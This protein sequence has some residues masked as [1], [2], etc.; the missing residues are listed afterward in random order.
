MNEDRFQLPPELL[1]RITAGHTLPDPLP[2]SPFPLFAEWF[3]SA[4]TAKSVP[5]PNAMTLAT[6]EPDGS[7]SARIVLCRGMS[8]DE[9]WIEFFTNYDG[10]KGRALRA[11]PVASAVFHL[12][13]DERQVRMSGPVSISPPES[14]DR[15]FATRPWESR[16]SAWASNQSQPLSSRQELL[17][18]IPKVMQQLGLTADQIASMGNATPIPR[19]PNWG[20][21]RILAATCELWLGG[22]GRL[23]DRALSSR[24]AAPFTPRIFGPWAVTR[25]NP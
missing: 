15:Y 7:P 6:V 11:N 9:G 17:A 4:A 12:Y 13:H 3:R 10:G 19:P 8:I 16:L 5:N 2:E 14:S 25:L 18:R 24:A 22:P 20:G 1:S 23:H 21:F